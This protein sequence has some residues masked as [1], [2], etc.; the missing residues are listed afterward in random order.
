MGALSKTKELCRLRNVTIKKLERDLGFANGYLGSK[1]NDDLPFERVLA[2]A[3]YFNV[4][5]DYFLSDEEQPIL[6]ENKETERALNFM[7]KFDKASPEIQAA[8]RTL[9]GD[10]RSDS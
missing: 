4:K 3:E 7:A 8:I 10:H 5:I 2:I 9:L 1:M 6:V